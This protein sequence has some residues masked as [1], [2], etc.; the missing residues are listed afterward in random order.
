VNTSKLELERLILGTL[1]DGGDI[2]RLGLKLTPNHFSA[3]SRD[4]YT[5]ILSLV[6]R[7][8]KP[9]IV[10]VSS[11]STA[12]TA[13]VAT[14]TNS[15]A[16]SDANLEFYVEKLMFEWQRESTDRIARQ[17]LADIDGDIAEVMDTALSRI[18]KVRESAD[19]EKDIDM[20][21]LAEILSKEAEYRLRHPDEP[22]GIDLSIRFLDLRTKGFEP[23]ESWIVGARTSMGKSALLQFIAN[24]IARRGTP[25]SIVSMEMTKQEIGYRLAA[26]IS[27]INQQN[28]KVPQTQSQLETAKEAYQK[29][30]KLPL[31]IIARSRMSV[32][33]LKSVVRAE[34][35]RHGTRVVFLD[36]LNLVDADDRTLQRYLQI[37]E[38]SRA[39][40]QLALELEIA[41]MSAC[42]L[43]RHAEGQ[44]PTLADLRESGDLEQDADVVLLMHREKDSDGLLVDRTQIIIAKQRNGPLGSMF[45]DFNG[46]TMQFAET[47]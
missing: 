6:D 32:T 17:T 26:Q 27:G 25:V 2:D 20:P 28:L 46:G 12:S 1:I 45:L 19:G 38:I 47:R 44:R 9:D 33:E 5:T 21:E 16:P 14:L 39:L 37:Q 8:I 36:Y 7:G 31:H 22:L 41:I 40:K 15:T 43:N 34:V 13:E 42:Q 24:N 29:L 11:E 30:G 23:G 18:E 10:S 3:K 35:R 4:I